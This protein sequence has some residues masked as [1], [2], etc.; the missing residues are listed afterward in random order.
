[1]VTYKA[2]GPCTQSGHT[3][4]ISEVGPHQFNL[5][6]YVAT[7]HETYEGNIPVYTC[8]SECD[9]ATIRER[10][11][12]EPASVVAVTFTLQG[13]YVLCEVCGVIHFLHTLGRTSTEIHEQ[14]KSVYGEKCI[15]LVMVGK[16]VKQFDA[17]RTDVHDLEQSLRRYLLLHLY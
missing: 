14:L 10:F 17:G 4:D 2:F 11:D 6:K 5:G 16:W 8:D 3:R 15:S 12:D 1:M 7:N 13:T 9:V